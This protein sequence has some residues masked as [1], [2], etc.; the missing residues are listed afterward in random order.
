MRALLLVV[1]RVSV[2]LLL[3]VVTTG[4]VVVGVGVGV[5]ETG[6]VRGTADTGATADT[7]VTLITGDATTCCGLDGALA[8]PAGA[9]ADDGFALGASN[10]GG[11]SAP[12]SFQTHALAR[13][14]AYTHA[15]THTPGTS[16]KSLA[17]VAAVGAFVP[18]PS[19]ERS[20][21]TRELYS[22]ILRKK[23]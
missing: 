14:P 20:S 22:A 6:V 13:K 1:E 3:L 23:F 19:I 16:G 12:T 10:S 8:A 2:S 18:A 15:H 4:A 9:G 17:G 5:V 11:G 21:P 7:G